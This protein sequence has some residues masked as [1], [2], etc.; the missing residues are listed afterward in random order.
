MEILRVYTI[1]CDHEGF[2]VQ[3]LKLSP[4]QIEERLNKESSLAVWTQVLELYCR[5]AA[6]H[7][8]PDKHLQL[9]LVN[10]FRGKGVYM[11][12]CQS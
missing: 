10:A 11:D 12:L 2:S 1:V 3:G 8:E 4:E 9:A 7:D 6:T 5:D